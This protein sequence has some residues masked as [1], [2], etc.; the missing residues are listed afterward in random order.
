MFVVVLDKA[1]KADGTKQSEISE[2]VVQRIV[3]EIDE[4]EK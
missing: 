2:Q 4:E 1:L 3:L